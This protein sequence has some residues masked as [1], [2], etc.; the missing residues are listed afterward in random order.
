MGGPAQ[1]ADASAPDPIHT[2]DRKLRVYLSAVPGELAPELAAARSAIERLRLTPVT[3]DDAARPHGLR[4]L[5]RAYLAQSD[6]FVGIYCQ[7][8]GP[9]APGAPVSPLEDEYLRAG[10]R[11]KLIYVKTPAPQ[12]EPHLAVLLQRV[13]ADDT[14]SYKPFVAAEDLRNSLA[15]DLAILLS[16]EFAQPQAPR[17]APTGPGAGGLPLPRRSLVNRERELALAQDLLLREDV[18]LVTLT[19]PGGS[20][21]SRLVLHIAQ[22]LAPRF[23]DGVAWVPLAALA[24]PAQVLPAVAHALD[25]REVP[26]EPLAETVRAAVRAR[27]L[28][29]LLDNFEHVLAAAPVVADLLG[30]G[31]RL[32][33]LVTSR[34]PLHLSMEHELPVPPLALPDADRAHDRAGIAQSAAVA[35]FIQRARDVAPGFAVTDET[36]P[37]VAEICARLDGLPLAIE[38]AAA[39]SRLLSPRALLAR[40]ERR[41]PMLTGGPRD[42]PA[43]QQTLR[44]AIAWSYDLLDAPEQ[45]LF[46][47]LSV[48]RWGFTL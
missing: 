9:I 15:D 7:Q 46:R 22:A 25:I 12:R 6:V 10:D 42:L 31:P 28:L 30:A 33:V 17:A 11:P 37:V 32:R 45:A 18:G 14:A 24:D 27:H 8:Y 5:S 13:Q 19:G 40:L 38:L 3:P 41:L 34:A 20:G 48:F 1:P 23:A 21:K 44:A 47:R 39:R 16:E 26:A 35:L 2:P 4:D 43:R 36:A 29:L